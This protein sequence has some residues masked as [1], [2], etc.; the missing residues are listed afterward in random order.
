MIY[1]AQIDIPNGPVKIGTAKDPV[2][3]IKQFNKHLPWLLKI[4][5]IYPGDYEQERLIHRKF[6][7]FRM[8]DSN[9]RE[10][11]DSDVL[12]FE[13]FL[14]KISERGLTA[15][16][17]MNNSEIKEYIEI[18]LNCVSSG[19]APDRVE[20]CFVLPHHALRNGVRTR[21]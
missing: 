13:K 1:F 2:K 11:F 17:P 6:I 3:R 5:S 8:K 10:W 9:G 4:V 7:R 19:K 20:K 16:K 15:E 12:K 14:S 21:L 18:L